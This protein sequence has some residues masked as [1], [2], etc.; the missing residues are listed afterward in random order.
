MELN[1]FFASVGADGRQVLARFPGED[2]LRR[3]LRKFPGDP[4]YA[5]L[6]AAL[7]S[8]NL[9]EA[10]RAAHTLKG[11]AAN[12]GLEDLYAAASELTEALRGASDLP[13]QQSVQAVARAYR[14]VVDSIALLDD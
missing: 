2:M 12:L 4:S 9:S 1:A 8:G 3:F 14:T 11:T 5:M 13:P 6:Q 7:E 10:F